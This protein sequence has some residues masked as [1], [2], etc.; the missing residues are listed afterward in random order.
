MTAISLQLVY[1]IPNDNGI[2]VLEFGEVD[3]KLVR[4]RSSLAH[5]NSS[6]ESANLLVTDPNLVWMTNTIRIMARVVYL[7][8]LMQPEM[9]WDHSPRQV[10]RW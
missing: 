2:P 10:E 6:H 4:Q 9:Y 3:K 8:A 5:T 1:R 7:T